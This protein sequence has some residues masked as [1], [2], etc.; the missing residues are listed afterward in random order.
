V[1]TKLTN[2]DEEYVSI[3]KDILP[4]LGSQDEKPG[5]QDMLDVML[6]QAL[7]EMKLKSDVLF[8]I[9]VI[10]YYSHLIYILNNYH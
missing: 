7:M 5:L 4:E 9:V 10:C 6:T 3:I 8:N 1:H 2:K